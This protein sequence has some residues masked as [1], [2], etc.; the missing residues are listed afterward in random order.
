MR[1]KH[2]HSLHLVHRYRRDVE[3]ARSRRRAVRVARRRLGVDADLNGDGNAE[4]AV[5]ADHWRERT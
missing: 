3:R 1:T 5:I 2:P 4:L